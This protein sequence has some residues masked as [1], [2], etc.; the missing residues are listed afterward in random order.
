MIWYRV[1][2]KTRLRQLWFK[3]KKFEN[4]SLFFVESVG[5][6]DY[7]EKWKGQLL[8]DANQII[9]GEIRYYAYHW[10]PIGNPPNWFLNPYN[11]AQYPNINN[12]WTNLPDFNPKIGDIKNVWEAS[13]FE[14]VV[15]LARAYAVTNEKIY[16][17]TLNCWLAN[18]VEKNSLNTGPNWKCGQ[19]TSIRL[20][21]LLNAALILNQ[22]D[23]PSD[24]LQ[25]LIYLSLGRIKG[26]ILYAIAQ[27]NNHGTSEAAGLFIGGE[28]L[29]NINKK[30]FPKAAR[31]AKRG[32]Y[33][34]ENRINK[35]ISSDGS[36][37]QHSA[38]YHRLMLDTLCFAEYWRSKLKVKEFSSGFNEKTKAAINWL[39]LITD[40]KSGDAPNLGANDGAFLLNTHSGNYRDFRPTLQLAERLFTCANEIQ[41]SWSGEAL[42][43]FGLNPILKKQV[44]KNSITLKSGY[45]T[46]YAD[47]SWC[48]IR[49]PFFKFRPSHNDVMHFDL[50]VNGQNVICDSGTFSYNPGANEAQ[51]DYKSVQFHNTVSFDGK[52][53]MPKLGRFLLGNWLI[54]EKIEKVQFNPDGKQEWQGSYFDN[55]GNRHLRGVTVTENVWQI[56]DTLS[57]N[58]K[59][60]IIGFNIADMNCKLTENRLQTSFGSITISK[61]TIP[62]LIESFASDFYMEKQIIKR[63][64]LK[65][66][67]PGI[68]QT[69]I[70]L[71]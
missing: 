45:T 13:R 60:A 61:N 53:Q 56:T 3:K 46:M 10:Q 68:F 50:W 42:Y 36:F 26:N 44:K 23:K 22:Y 47:N 39:W 40:E 33:W 52:E 20:F 19:E 4:K 71:K 28:W 58:F 18:W 9:N 65:T 55:N 6:T 29:N 59:E 51:I 64:I 49:W 62:L 25:E 7:P 1:S 12:H 30:K 43:W 69:T 16:L 66:S 34:L 63:L 8:N 11:G 24:S 41:N 21:N 37:S 38:T 54:S 32:R 17:D 67:K 48:L 70:E 35:L 5:R 57:G 2:L 31:Y 14:W 27:D 15:T